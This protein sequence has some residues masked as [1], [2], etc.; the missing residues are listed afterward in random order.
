MLQVFTNLCK[1]R[2]VMSSWLEKTLVSYIH[3]NLTTVIR[4]RILFAPT[5]YSYITSITQDYDYKTSFQT[6]LFLEKI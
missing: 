5:R 4:C 6:S 2:I 1:L 3:I